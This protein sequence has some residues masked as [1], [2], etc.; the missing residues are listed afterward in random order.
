MIYFFQALGF[1]IIMIH[2]AIGIKRGFNHFVC[3]LASICWF[4]KTGYPIDKENFQH[5]I[6][7][8]VVY[9]GVL[10]FDGFIAAYF[11]FG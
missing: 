3:A 9:A 8:F 6:S 1:I 4:K 11:I 10:V 2:A 7:L 5:H